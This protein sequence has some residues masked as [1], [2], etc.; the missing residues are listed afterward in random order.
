MLSSL[1]LSLHA[2]LKKINLKYNTFPSGAPII[3]LNCS[4]F[5]S[6]RKR[7]IRSAVYL[8]VGQLISVNLSFLK[9][10]ARKSVPV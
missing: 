8:E 6:Y 4:N 5:F 2:F 3:G 1:A 7:Q 9:A 10:V